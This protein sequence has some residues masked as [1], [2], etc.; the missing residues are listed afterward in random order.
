MRK[1]LLVLTLIVVC[2]GLLFAGG[3]EN[4]LN[5][6]A[7]YARFPA[8][9]TECKKPD[10]MFYNPAGTAFL[11][12]GL[13]V[14]A[15]N[16]FLYKKYTNKF[17]GESYTSDVPTYL[18]PDLTLVWKKN[19]TALFAGFTVAAGGGE[20]EY[21]K[22]NAMTK[23]ALASMAQ[24]MHNP[25]LAA[26]D[27]SLNVYSVL[28]DNIIGISHQFWDD[29]LSI[30]AAVRILYGSRNIKIKS[31]DPQ[32]YWGN[33]RSMF[34]TEASGFG[35]GGIFS[36]HYK[37]IET[38]DIAATYHTE[39][40]IDYEYNKAKVL[41]SKLN[42]LPAA[43]QANLPDSF[44]VNKGDHFSYVLPAYLG[45]GVG[46]QIIPQLYAA[47][48][49]NY[50]F[51][52]LADYEFDDAWE[53]NFGAEYRFNK[54]LAVS[55]GGFYTDIGS[56]N[57]DGGNDVTNPYLDSF[58]YCG[59]FELTFFDDLTIDVGAFYVH[60]FGETYKFYGQDVK[61]NKKIFEGAIS[62]TYRFF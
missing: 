23:I 57:K 36:I 32:P 44:K 6:G 56:R 42:E 9:A 2:T 61:L 26:V 24:S 37:P 16:Q 52:Q 35:T 15:G 38:V 7:G 21:D 43:V 45:G 12:D 28:Y 48:G 20:L 41:G 18:Y 13:Y 19:E 8:K 49:F 39:S 55:L 58:T 54:M 25:A 50:Y 30:A 33:Q 40:I 27:H 22:G 10:A 62:V 51:N 47:V 59:G 17:N 1:T 53:I 14:G 60:Y 11:K 3:T 5:S 29:H 46:W 4:K 34:D 31:D